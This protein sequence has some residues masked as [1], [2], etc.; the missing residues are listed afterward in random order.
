MV[1][2]ESHLASLQKRLLDRNYPQNVIDTQFSK[3]KKFN[4]KNLINQPKRS[5]NGDSKVRLIF[6]QN[7]GG[8]PLHK[9]IRE[10]Q[11][12]LVKNDEAKEMCKKLQ[13]AY[14]QPKNLQQIVC[15]PDKKA[16][17]TTPE[18]VGCFKCNNCR[19]SCPVLTEG[20]N[21]RSSNTG[22]TYKIKQF[23]NCNS[24]NVIYLAT[25][26]KCRGQYVGKCSTI[27]KVRHSNHKQEIKRSYG[28]LG[29]HYGGPS[30]CGYQNLTLQII[31][32]IPEGDLITLGKREIYWQN[33][34]R[35]FIEN[36]GGAH[37]YRKET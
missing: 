2:S 11:K 9:W 28:G 13:V 4:K 18:V 15:G 21:F 5:K 35:A 32:K 33:Q 8:P 22:R 37:C 10:C 20:E 12:L 26:K 25:C 34:L 24:K 17:N 36:G 3:A 6:T 14:R 30:G 27:F 1:D 19:V 23:V 7:S 16:C 31:E 29:H